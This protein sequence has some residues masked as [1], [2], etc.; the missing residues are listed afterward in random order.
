[1]TKERLLEIFQAYVINDYEASSMDYIREALEEV[2]AP[3]EIEE[4]GFGWVYTESLV[5]TENE[6]NEE[7]NW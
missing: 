5:Y 7:D 2:A 6:D 3:E 1:M 4:L